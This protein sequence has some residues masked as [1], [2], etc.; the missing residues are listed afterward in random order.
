MSGFGNARKRLRLISLQEVFLS[1]LDNN[2]FPGN[3]D[4]NRQLFK[5]VLVFRSD[6]N[7][8]ERDNDLIPLYSCPAPSFLCR[9]N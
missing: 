2:T 8:I 7:E 9:E 5:G 6:A 3:D 1:A 4:F